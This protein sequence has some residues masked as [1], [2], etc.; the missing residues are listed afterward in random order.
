MGGRTPPT[1]TPVTEFL[2]GPKLGL[3]VAGTTGRSE[4]ALVV[5]VGATVVAVGASVA[6]TGGSVGPADGE[7]EIVGAEVGKTKAGPPTSLKEGWGVGTEGACVEVVGASVNEIGAVAGAAIDDG[8][9][10]TRACVGDPVGRK[11]G[12]VVKGDVGSLVGD[13]VREDVGS[14][15]GETVEGSVGCTVGAAVTLLGARVDGTGGS[16]GPAEGEKEIVGV[17][18]GNKKAGPP[19]SL[20]DGWCVGTAG[21]SVGDSD[22]SVIAIGAIG[23]TVGAATGDNDGAEVKGACVGDR[24]GGKVGIIVKGGVGCLVGGDVE[25]GVGGDVAS[26]DG[27][28]V[29]G[30]VGPLVGDFV[31]E[32]VVATEAGVGDTGWGVGATGASVGASVGAIGAVVDTAGTAFKMNG[33]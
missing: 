33:E 7:N 19:T 22:G 1:T 28:D 6:G 27:G 30:G 21:A 3:T 31:G 29:G 8:A 12:T 5:L 4:G 24:E 23:A 26:F 25:S 18:V 17:V 11:L 2:V 9:N 15:L 16:V 20:K 32:D 14:L 13:D 10:V